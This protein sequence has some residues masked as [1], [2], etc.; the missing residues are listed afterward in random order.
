M[1]VD[2][3]ASPVSVSGNA[4]LFVLRVCE[5]LVYIHKRMSFKRGPRAVSMVP[6]KRFSPSG[7]WLFIV[8]IQHIHGDKIAVSTR[9]P[10]IVLKPLRNRGGGVS[11][12]SRVLNPDPCK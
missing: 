1:F 12:Q 7:G 3:H 10:F 9:H 8:Q 2:T 6:R 4:K 11:V 5:L